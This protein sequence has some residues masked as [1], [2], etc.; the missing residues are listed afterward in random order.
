MISTGGGVVPKIVGCCTG[1][2]LL[3]KVRVCCSSKLPIMNLSD[4]HLVAWL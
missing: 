3:D 4:A 2:L 1:T